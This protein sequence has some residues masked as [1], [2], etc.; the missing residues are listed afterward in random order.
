MKTDHNDSILWT[1]LLSTLLACSSGEATPRPGVPSLAEEEA[2]VDNLGLDVAGLKA[3]TEWYRAFRANHSPAEGK[4][5]F[6]ILE[7]FRKLRARQLKAAAPALAEK[8][9]RASSPAHVDQLMAIYVGVPFDKESDDY[10]AVATAA[11]MR[12]EVAPGR[13]GGEG[14]AFAVR[15]KAAPSVA[16]APGA[17]PDPVT[18]ATAAARPSSGE[19]SEREMLGAVQDAFAAQR[20]NLKDMADDCQGPASR[21]DP[22]T[23]VRCLG[24]LMVGADRGEVGFRVKEFRKLGCA[25]A[26]GQPGW[27]CDYVAS[28]SG[29][30][31]MAAMNSL[32]GGASMSQGRFVPRG[33]GRWLLIPKQPVLVREY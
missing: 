7:K 17:A 8:V 30:G 9:K 29:A 11:N 4:R 2:I 3:G 23:N 24:A 19:P 6:A 26:Q 18:E 31:S 20:Q 22:I 28:L 21:R 1:V 10:L 13:H 14:T 33:G 25:K 27:V 16:A 32:V 12:K 5:V 15:A